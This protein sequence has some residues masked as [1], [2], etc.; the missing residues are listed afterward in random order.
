MSNVTVKT[1][2]YASWGRCVQLSNGKVEL[3]ATLDFGPRIIRY[4]FVGGEN[5]LKEDAGRT[6]GNSDDAIQDAYGDR[7]WRIYGGH[8]LWVSPEVLP[9][10][11]YP[12]NAPV[13]WSEV[14]RGVKLTPPAEQ[15]NGIQ[16]EIELTLAADSEEV[17]V[18]QRV[19]NVGAWPVEFAVWSLT[20]MDVG[21]REILPQNRRET[22]FLA[23][24]SL[25]LW[26]YTRMSDPRVRWGDNYIVIRQGD[27]PT[28][29]KIGTANEAGWVAYENKGQ[30]FIKYHPHNPD[31]VYP[32]FGVSYETYVCGDFIELE[33]LGELK[34][35]APGQT[36]EHHEVWNLFAGVSLPGDDADEA[37]LEQAL[38]AYL[39]K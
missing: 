26:P 35:V 15:G 1:L 32:D 28:P 37:A 39:K 30:L 24:R 4:G 10:T 16:K 21:G 25:V 14:E 5:M 33:T 18:T 3:I 19:T 23:N 22:G 8:R 17:T 6:L 29:F 20:V 38:T 34:M 27:G 13:Q 31:G 11:Y 7:D 36:A 12:D 9:R 2:E